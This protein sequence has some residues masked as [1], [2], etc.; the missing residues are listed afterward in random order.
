M[1]SVRVRKGHQSRPQA[2]FNQPPQALDAQTRQGSVSPLGQESQEDVRVTHSL[3]R[4]ASKIDNHITRFDVPSSKRLHTVSSNADNAGPSTIPNSPQDHESNTHSTRNHERFTAIPGQATDVRVRSDPED[5]DRTSYIGSVLSTADGHPETRAPLGAGLRNLH[6]HDDIVE[7]LDV[8]DAQ[9]ATVSNLTNAANS[10]LI[11]PLAFYSRKPVVTLFAPPPADMDSEKYGNGAGDSLD[12][13]VDD[14]LKR[15]SK[16]RR[17]LRGVWSFLKTP[18]GIIT[19]IYGF[20][21][22]FWGAAIVLFLGKLINLHNSNTQGFWVEVSS[23]VVNGLFTVTGV[24]LI[25]FR[26]LDTYRIYRIW[27]FKR[28]TSKLRRQAGLPQLLDVDDLPDPYY[29]VNYVHVLT[30]E[31]QKE[32]HRHQVK[33]HHSQTWYRAHGTDTHRAFPINTALVIC[34]FNDGNSVFQVILCATMWSMNRFERP[35]WSTGLLIPASFLCGIAAGIFIWRGG[36]KTRRREEIIEKLRA[37]LAME[38]DQKKDDGLSSRNETPVPARVS[39]KETGSRAALCPKEKVLPG[40][41]V[42]ERMVIPAVGAQA[43]GH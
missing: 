2:S 31:E 30:D 1:P 11:P 35:A 23:Q 29:D 22:V 18:M 15:P 19:G 17:T 42:E 37:V 7:H 28:R 5:E 33:F 8:I 36:Q 9:V 13:H 21:V 26:I 38:F 4:P 3:R 25:P 10:I 39:E 32:L 27:H 14:V 12:R 20:L 41:A 16:I 40:E 43:N 6:H 24:G 34:L